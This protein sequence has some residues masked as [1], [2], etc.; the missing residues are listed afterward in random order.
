MLH[1]VLDVH[2]SADIY[3]ASRSLLRLFDMRL[4][5]HP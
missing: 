4:A 3:G 5:T 2:N 1:R